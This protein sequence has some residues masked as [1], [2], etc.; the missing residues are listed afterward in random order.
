MWDPPFEDANDVAIKAMCSR[1]TIEP[2]EGI[3]DDERRARFK[4][5]RWSLAL[6]SSTRS[7]AYE[8]SPS[9]ERH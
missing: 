7:N 1:K 9:I 6:N 4:K 3:P 8:L 2:I 5:R